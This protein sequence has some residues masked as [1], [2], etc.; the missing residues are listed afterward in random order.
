M[1]MLE[2]GT[3]SMFVAERLGY[4]FVG[5]CGATWLD[6]STGGHESAEF[7]FSFLFLR[8]YIRTYVRMYV[9]CSSFHC[10]P[11][12]DQRYATNAPKYLAFCT[13]VLIHPSE[14]L[15]IVILKGSARGLSPPHARRAL[16]VSIDSAWYYIC[17]VVIYLEVIVLVVVV[18]TLCLLLLLLSLLL[19]LL[20]FWMDSP[21][22]R[23][24][25]GTTTRSWITKR[26]ARSCTWPSRGHISPYT[27]RNWSPP[28]RSVRPP[29]RTPGVG[30]GGGGGGGG[31]RR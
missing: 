20:F 31:L 3:A 25:Q 16:V 24:V 11:H 17:C 8:T 1:F 28:E 4:F 27:F 7:L 18:V 26:L 23:Q 10:A 15:I 13:L 6:P 19:L 9:T 29:P 12:L 30:R 5:V 2:L 21:A 14:C 22:W